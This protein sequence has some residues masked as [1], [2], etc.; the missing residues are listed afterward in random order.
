MTSDK[1]PE[2]SVSVE[3]RQNGRW[4]F[5]IKF[6]GVTYP[7]QGNFTSMLEAQASAQSVLKGLEK[8]G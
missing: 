4:C 1:K 5:V 7:A 3:K 2:T 8:Q 6:R